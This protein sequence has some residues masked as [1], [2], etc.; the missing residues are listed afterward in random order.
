MAYRDALTGLY[1]RRHVNER[2]PTLLEDALL[3]QGPISLAIL[4]LDH[5]KR[6]NDTLSHSVG[7][8]VLQ[9]VA[10]LLQQET[11][12]STVAARLGGEEFVLIMPG[13]GAQEAV[14]RC[15]RL[16]L[17]I[18][19]HQWEPVTG[20]LPVTTSI[21][22]ATSER[23][24]GTASSLLST[25]DQHLYAAKRAGRDRVSGGLEAVEP[26]ARRPESP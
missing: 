20:R 13:V 11:N 14:R 12:G 15:E 23:G 7:D 26:S 21:G 19:A 6:V 10:H 24:R 5:F 16:R 22:V 18:R 8:T 2:L 1:N 17:R 4:D 25:A 3:R 9:Q